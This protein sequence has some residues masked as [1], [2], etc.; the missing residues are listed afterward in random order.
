M[1]ALAD[2]PR[3]AAFADLIN[4]SYASLSAAYVSAVHAV[5]GP[6]GTPMKVFAWT[7]DDPATART[8]AEYDVDGVITNRPDV[9]RR[10]LYRY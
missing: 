8:V 1:P 10:A 9:V 5:T 3:Y 4:P 2:L 6:H 7:V